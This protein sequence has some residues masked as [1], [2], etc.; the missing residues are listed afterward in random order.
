MTCCWSKF[1]VV[2]KIEERERERE[3]KC[4][5]SDLNETKTYVDIKAPGV[6]II[7]LKTLGLELSL[8][9]SVVF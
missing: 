5:L 8:S 2:E 3:T 1:Q 9:R 7:V 4:A 6:F